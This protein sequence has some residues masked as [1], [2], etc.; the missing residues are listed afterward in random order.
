MEELK[1]YIGY[2]SRESIAYHVA[3]HSILKN[4]KMNTKLAN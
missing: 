1:I 2:D 3:K 4:T